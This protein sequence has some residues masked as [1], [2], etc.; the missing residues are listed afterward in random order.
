MTTISRLSLMVLLVC[1]AAAACRG[2]QDPAST[3]ATAVPPTDVMTLTLEAKPV[4]QSSEFVATI[5]SLR[6]TTVQP[7]VEGVRPADPRQVPAIASRAG[8]PL[9]QIDPRPAAGDGRRR[10][11]RSGRR[12]RRISRLRQQQLARMQKL[13]EAGAVS[14][15]ELEQAESVAQER[16]GAARRRCGRRS[17]RTQVQLQTTTVSSRRP[18]ASSAT[19]RFARA[20]ASRPST[21]ITTIDQAQGLEAY[22]N[23]PLERSAD[24]RRGTDR[25]NCSTATVR[26]IASNPV[27]FVAPR[28]DDA[29][30]SVLVKATLRQHAAGAARDAVRARA[31]H[32]EQ[33]ARRWRCRWW[34]SAGS[35]GSTSCS[36]PEAGASRDSSRGR[37]RS[38]SAPSSATDYVV[39]ARPQGRRAGHRVEHPED[40]RRRAGEGSS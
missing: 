35:P 12:A 6:S 40:R 26:S 15:A 7:Q 34:R 10:S 17:A 13:F 28:A 21:A 29:T 16:P 39:A 33:R 36:S 3:S 5:R 27:T 9:L 25:S 31:A 20:I 1:F 18:P 24:L 38:R 30:Q 37:S 11:N 32:L 4:P 22:I 8:Q 23:V 2:N 14:R 19:S